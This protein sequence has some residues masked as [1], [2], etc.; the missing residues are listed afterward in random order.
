MHR[1]KTEPLQTLRRWAEVAPD[2]QAVADADRSLTYSELN[3]AVTAAARRLELQ[4]V[5][6]ADRVLIVAENNVA[7]VVLLFAAQQLQAWPAIVNARAAPREI[8]AMRSCAAPSCVVYA[9]DGAQAALDLAVIE[10]AVIVDEPLL[11]RI[12]FAR[13][14]DSP[15][16]PPVSTTQDVGLLIFTSGTLGTPKAVMWSRIALS[17]LGQ[18][19]AASRSTERADVVNGMAPLSHIM[20]IANLMSALHAG[21]VLRLM[22]RFELPALANA[23]ANGELTHLSF[24]PTAYARLCAYIESHAI[25]LSRHRLRYISCGGAPLSSSLKYKVESLFGVRLVNGYGM[26]ECAPGTRTRP[27]TA[28]PANCIGWPEAGVETRIVDEDRKEV[29]TGQT[30]EL[31]LRS[32]AV[33]LGYFNN[34]EETAA[35]LRPGGWLATGDLAQRAMDGSLS[36][37]GRKK[38]MIIVSGFNVYPAEVE[39]ALTSVPEVL[40]A[41]VV[42]RKRH[43]GE[44][45]VI[46]FVQLRSAG[47][48][49]EAEITARLRDLVAPYK[50]PAR[51]VIVESLPLGQTGKISKVQLSRWAAELSQI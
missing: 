39:A 50:R 44:E 49:S 48:A 24:V 37:V 29:G 28:V 22:A 12:M 32:E 21:A 7:T 46:A 20:G 15:I 33:M 30:G 38:E 26:T 45:E 14:R 34:P 16:T 42:G 31:W 5:Q 51:M 6:R 19:L 36:I 17:N 1:M 2:Q 47:A 27:D 35:A 8:M 11:G 41:G 43:D 4:G 40:L 18:I 25:D 13:A 23:I 10:G 9:V 3:L